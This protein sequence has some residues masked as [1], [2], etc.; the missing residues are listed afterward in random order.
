[1]RGPQNAW[2]AH[3]RVQ[4]NIC[5]YRDPIE[6]GGLRRFGDLAEALPEV[7]WSAL[8]AGFDDAEP[9][10]RFRAAAWRRCCRDDSPDQPRSVRLFPTA[11]WSTFRAG[12]A[13][14]VVPFATFESGSTSISNFFAAARIF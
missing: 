7:W 3:D 6:A 2:A 12:G 11:A 5:G 10:L 4:P 14:Q 8:P 1:M 13:S 9:D